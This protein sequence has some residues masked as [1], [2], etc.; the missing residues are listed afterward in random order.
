MAERVRAKT[1]IDLAVAHARAE[2]TMRPATWSGRAA[3]L[4]AAPVSAP[5]A[6]TSPAPTS[7]APAAPAAS[8]PEPARAVP[9]TAAPAPASG[10]APAASLEG[11][12]PK[13][14]PAPRGGKPDDLR[15]IR[16]IGPKNEGVLNALGIYHYQQIAA[17]TPANIAWLDAYMKFPG[18]IARDDWVG[19]AR[20]LLGTD[21]KAATKVHPQDAGA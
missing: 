15:R 3:P 7:P 2:E 16:G 12:K 1:E 17:L 13:G 21:S 10:G 11:E 18:R 6:P 14:L 4:P 19:Q 8:A 5:P 9:T 20:L